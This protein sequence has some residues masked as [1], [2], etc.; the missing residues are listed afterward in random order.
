MAEFKKVE[1]TSNDVISDTVK[2]LVDFILEARKNALKENIRANTVLLDET[3]AKVNDIHFVVGRDIL[4]IPPMICGLEVRLTDELPDGYDFALVE[5][6][7]TE[8]ERIVRTAK[9]EVAREIFEEIEKILNES[10][11]GEYSKEFGF[12]NRV[13]YNGYV[14]GKGLAELKEKYTE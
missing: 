7:E 10:R 6:P 14:L 12:L 1:L 3:F 9:T 4:H 13:S 5:A 2:S 11:Q 8:R